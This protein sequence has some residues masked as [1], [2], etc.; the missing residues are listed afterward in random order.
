MIA[1]ISNTLII[2]DTWDTAK[3]QNTSGHF[4]SVQHV[5]APLQTAMEAIFSPQLMEFLQLVLRGTERSAAGELI[6]PHVARRYISSTTQLEALLKLRT[7]VTLHALSSVLTG[8]AKLTED[9]LL[10]S[11]R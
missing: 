8:D 10:L 4:T 6:L 5:I 1:V 2:K 11:P 3:A 9:R 7:K